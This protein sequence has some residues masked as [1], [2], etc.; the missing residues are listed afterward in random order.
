MLFRSGLGLRG[1]WQVVLRCGP[2]V[3]GR[4]LQK[5]GLNKTSIRIRMEIKPAKDV[6]AGPAKSGDL[7]HLEGHTGVSEKQI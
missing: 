1:E 4:H 5:K 6:E 7:K 2:G 3:D